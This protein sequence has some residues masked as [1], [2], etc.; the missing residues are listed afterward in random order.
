MYARVRK[1]DGVVETQVGKFDPDFVAPPVPPIEEDGY[2]YFL[3]AGPLPW[4][5]CPGETYVLLWN[6]GAPIWAD[7]VPLDE[8]RR[9]AIAR[10]YPDVD[11]VYDD[12]IGRRATEYADAEAAARA[13]M[14][15]EVKPAVVSE[16]ITDHALN[17]PTGQVQSEAWAAQQIIERAD[18]FRW[19]Q[20][21]MRSVRFARQADMRAAATPEELAVAVREWG[22]FITWLR[23]TL[24]L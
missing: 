18:A 11:A 13:Y 6:D 7:P 2:A 10:T 19:A 15:A 1:A 8:H 23:A 9:R 20:L 22:D 12:A 5:E 14:A 17:N 21:Q 24:D 3:L 16:Y 4:A